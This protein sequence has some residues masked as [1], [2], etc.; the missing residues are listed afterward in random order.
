ML[1]L[2]SEVTLVAGHRHGS[3][4]IL[5][6]LNLHHGLE[7]KVVKLDLRGQG[8]QMVRGYLGLVFFVFVHKPGKNAKRRKKEKKERR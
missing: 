5:G 6:Y 7:G 2:T 8:K 4:S 3:R 1:R